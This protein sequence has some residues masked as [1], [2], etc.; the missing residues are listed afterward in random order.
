MTSFQLCISQT[1]PQ[2]KW[3][4]L[5]WQCLAFWLWPTLH[6]NMVIP[7]T[8]REAKNHWQDLTQTAELNG[9]LSKRL[10]MKKLLN[11]KRKLF[12]LMSAKMSIKL[13]A[14]MFRYVN[15]FLYYAPDQTSQIYFGLWIKFDAFSQKTKYYFVF[16]IVELQ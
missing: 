16:I 7:T 5:F 14:K 3:R 6:P 11:T 12:I 2:E 13:S 10:D 8:F 1:K 9:R 15:T 4:L